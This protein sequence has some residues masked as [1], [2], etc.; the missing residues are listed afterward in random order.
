MSTKHI[1]IIAVGQVYLNEQLNEYL[2]VTKNN[3][4]QIF[5]AGP[6]F[7][8]Q[9]EVE[10]FVERFQPVNPEDVIEK[11]L[12]TLLSFCPV[13]TSASTGFIK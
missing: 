3:F 11:E 12:L 13:N 10:S 7:K 6:N 1:P 5:Y 4:G 9:A 8:G 2:I